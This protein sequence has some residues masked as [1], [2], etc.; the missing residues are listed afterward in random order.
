[1]D[2]TGQELDEYYDGVNTS[3]YI[4]DVTSLDNPVLINVH[5]HG[6]PNIDHNLYVE[7]NYV[8]QSHYTAGLRIHDISNISDGQMEE[9]AFFDI[10]PENNSVS[11]D[12]TWSNYPFFDKTAAQFSPSRR[13]ARSCT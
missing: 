10:H 8:Y 9:V 13:S 7:D 11:F 6:T 4:W 5:D 12:G 1:M 3:T 2:S